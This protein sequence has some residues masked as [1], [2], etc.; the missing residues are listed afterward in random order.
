MV[1]PLELEENSTLNAEVWEAAGLQGNGTFPLDR[2][3]YGNSAL[4]EVIFRH[5]QAANFNGITVSEGGERGMGG[6]CTG[7]VEGLDAGFSLSGAT[8]G[9]ALSKVYLS[10]E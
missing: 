7:E 5:V 10:I 6:N 4:L 3:S 2:F 8:G 1:V 9:V